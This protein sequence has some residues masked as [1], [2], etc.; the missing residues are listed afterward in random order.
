MS[1]Q[2][3]LQQVL[4]VGEVGLHGAALLT[5]LYVEVTLL[6]KGAVHVWSLCCAARRLRAP[7][8]AYQGELESLWDMVQPLLLDADVEVRGPAAAAAAVQAAAAAAATATAAVVQAPAAAVCKAR[9]CA[10]VG[11]YS[12]VKPPAQA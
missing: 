1:T 3:A 6:T 12:A 10:A 5:L 2:T 9:L 11:C 4:A 7:G 8:M